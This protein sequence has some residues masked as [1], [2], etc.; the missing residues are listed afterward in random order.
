MQARMTGQARRA[1]GIDTEEAARNFLAWLA[2]DANPALT[3]I[4]QTWLWLPAHCGGPGALRVSPGDAARIRAEVLA[5]W[6]QAAGPRAGRTGSHRA[7]RGSGGFP[8]TR[9]SSAIGAGTGHAPE[10]DRATSRPPA[11]VASPARTTAMVSAH[12]DR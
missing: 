9:H 10:P 8:G 7:A 1:A 2:A 12:D 3:E 6:P 11:P 4:I 5:A